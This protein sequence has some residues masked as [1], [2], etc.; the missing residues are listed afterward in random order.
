MSWSD[1]G[2]LEEMHEQRKRRETRDKSVLDEEIKERKLSKDKSFIVDR[3]NST[4]WVPLIG[5][6]YKIV[7]VTQFS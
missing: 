1:G 5:Y 4:M 6:I 3:D 2:E 7:I